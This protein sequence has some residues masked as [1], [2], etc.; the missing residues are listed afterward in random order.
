MEQKEEQSNNEYFNTKGLYRMPWTMADNSNVWLDVTRNCNIT[1][2]YCVQ[3]HT[4]N[5]TKNLETVAFEID[6]L[7]RL[8]KFQTMLIG[9]GE[10]LIHPDIIEIVKMIKARNKKPF[11]ITNGVDLTKDLLKD[12]KRAGLWGVKIHIDSGQQRP[13]WLNKSEKELNVLR[14]YYANMIHKEKGLVCSF[15]KTFF[16]GQ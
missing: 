7:I 15:I 5:S 1:C 12:L 3:D 2:E 11:I 6:E 14:D 13:E 4:C 16:H 9:G 8:R 10:P